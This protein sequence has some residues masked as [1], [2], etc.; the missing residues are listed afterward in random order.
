L[1]TNFEV[2]KEQIMA[3]LNK[4][5]SLTVKELEEMLHLSPA[6]VRRL[7][8]ALEKNGAV[9]RVRGGIR[10]NSRSQDTYSFD[11]QEKE[12]SAEKTRIA[13]YAV[14]QIHD[15]Q[16]VFL[17]SGSTLMQ[18]A[19][20]LAERIRVKNFSEVTVFTNSYLNMKILESVTRT[21][22][23]GGVYRS[24]RQDFAGILC[25]R[26]LSEYYF[27]HAII[28]ADAI[29]PNYGLMVLDFDTARIDEILTK[30]SSRLTV[31]AHSSK[32]WKNSLIPFASLDD[33]SS[34]ITDTGLSDEKLRSYKNAGCDVIRV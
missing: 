19:V 14:G 15:R 34:I 21:I 5:G 24:A 33:V 27:D 30:Q 8:A 7:A 10:L 11:I 31:V 20:A 4:K 1:N 23:V 16:T 12:A 2:R 29:N 28:G 3:E 18:C 13:R 32:F 6:S 22:L 17:E 26:I 25:E 9:L